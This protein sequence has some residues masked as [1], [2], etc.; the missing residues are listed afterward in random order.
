[1]GLASVV[2]A[3]FAL[4]PGYV[5]ARAAGALDFRRRTVVWR[6]A[7][8][9]VVSLSA[10]PILAYWLDLLG[11]P[12]AVWI[13][14]SALA[15]VCVVLMA[16]DMRRGE[17]FLGTFRLRDL[18]VV[19]ALLIG[20][21]ALAL[22]SLMDL[23]VGSDRIYTS[24][25]SADQSYRVSVTDAITRTG[26]AHPLNPL[27]HIHGAAFL[28]YHYFWFIFASLI[29]QAGGSWVDARSAFFA[30]TIWCGIGLASAVAL[31]LRFFARRQEA[32]SKT[33]IIKGILLL[34]VTGLDIIPN[35]TLAFFKDTRYMD[36]EGWNEAITSWLGSLL[37]APHSVA[38]LIAGVTGFLILFEAAENNQ[39]GRRSM[40]AVL[41]GILLATMIG[42]SIYVAFVL[43]A[44]LGV[45]TVITFLRG[46]TKHTRLLLVAGVT[47]VILALPYLISLMGPAGGGSF[48]Q[49]TVR[50]FR[51][52]RAFGLNADFASPLGTYLARLA[53]LPLN[54][55]LEL[56]FF[57][58]AGTLYVVRVWPS[59]R[60]EPAQVA[61]LTLVATSVLISTFLKS[62]VITNNDLGW[63]GFLPAQFVLVLWSVEVL[64]WRERDVRPRSY[65]SSI[66][67]S[68]LPLALVI[69]VAS[70][71]YS[72]I[73]LRSVELLNDRAEANR[74][75][76]RNRDARQIYSQ[77]RET[78]PASA[79][80]QQN[81]ALENPVYWGI[82]A[83][84][85]TAVGG[86][87]CGIEFG[88]TGSGCDQI[89]R[90]LADL[91]EHGD[92]DEQLEPLCRRL[93]INVLVVT[94]DDPIW[95]IAE[96]WVWRRTPLASAPEVRAFRIPSP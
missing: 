51:G 64:R 74:V 80:V 16:S 90:S 33:W 3:F 71:A 84:R 43:A 23:P 13:G 63:R 32:L 73:T 8:S 41:A 66:V 79:I 70:T 12:P 4:A 18:L 65:G 77:L 69:G 46:W 11:G 75:G 93:G 57:L 67:D 25:T 39:S 38:A 28:H 88:G 58:I 42:D 83:N 22:G 37:W 81:P 89:Y 1:M 62:G 26:I 30:S 19:A 56:G 21:A 6:C 55:F 5:L 85:Q 40:N 54:Y 91:F 72:A 36:M 95:G 76:K 49:F 7:I 47:A 44:F 60:R 2:A 27:T 87:N 68:L 78:L 14:F 50:D 48:L 92:R 53:F 86:R 82:Y 61:G 20:W 31:Y 52:A 45:W 10:V 96:S 9:V 35:F 59:H 17:I 94:S 24:V 15:A 29:D 34:G